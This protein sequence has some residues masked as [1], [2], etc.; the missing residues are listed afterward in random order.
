MITLDKILVLGIACLFIDG[1]GV[2]VYD[3]FAG[4]E[5][6]STTWSQ[7]YEPTKTTSVKNV[8]TDCPRDE[9][10]NNF[11]DYRAGI[12]SKEEMKNYIGGC[13]W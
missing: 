12:L 10:N 1:C 8:K 2:M 4:D 3:S 13:K 11:E 9:W 5:D 7:D 6:S